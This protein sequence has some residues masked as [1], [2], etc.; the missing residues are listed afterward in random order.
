M[1][2]IFVHGVPDT[3][4]VWHAVLARLKR[5]DVLTLSLP[6]FG[7]EVPAGFACTK[8]AY[9]DW[10]LAEVRKHSAPID[11]V[12]HD[13]GALLVLRAVCQEPDLIRSWAAGAAAID[14]TYKWHDAAAAWQTP[15]VGEQVMAGVTE[16]LVCSGL[17]AAGVPEADAAE[18]ARHVDERMK[19]SILKL[20]RSAIHVGEEW[21][22][23]LQGVRAPGLVM[24]GNDDPY[25][26]PDFGARV[27][28]RTRAKFVSW[29]HCS[30]WWP[31]QRPG[32]VA[33]ELESLWSRLNRN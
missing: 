31:L 33:A 15:Q 8:E 12:G 2:A 11:L 16:E 9:V 7:A 6:G 20:Y 21:Q 17:A 14:R 1:P 30:H 28:Q 23:D 26:T 13:W 10:L 3:H 5:K 27:A 19:S 25:S 4:R 29:P 18:A 22:D 32:D 24:W